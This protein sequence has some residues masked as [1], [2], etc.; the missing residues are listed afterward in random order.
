MA[1]GVSHILVKN[2]FYSGLH[3]NVKSVDMSM[4]I[5]IS[6]KFTRFVNFHVAQNIKY[7]KLI[8]CMVVD[9]LFSTS[10]NLSIFFDL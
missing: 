8:F 4:H 9:T 2:N 7:L 6:S 3:K 5:Y 1:N 10:R